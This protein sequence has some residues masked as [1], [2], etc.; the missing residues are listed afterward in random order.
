MPKM[1]STS[2]V[3]GMTSHIDDEPLATVD[4]FDAEDHVDLPGGGGFDV[5]LPAMLV[6]KSTSMVMP[7]TKST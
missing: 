1:K 5:P 7:M 6:M 2:M 4:R 3:M